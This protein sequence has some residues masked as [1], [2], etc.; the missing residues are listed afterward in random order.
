MATSTTPGTPLAST[1]SCSMGS[2]PAPAALTTMAP[3]LS[4]SLAWMA[5]HTATHGAWLV[6]VVVPAT[7]GSQEGRCKPA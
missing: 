4:I 1:V 6:L 2:K 7:S 3:P 5:V